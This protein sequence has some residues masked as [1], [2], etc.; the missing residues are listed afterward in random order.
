MA[1][2]YSEILSNAG[3]GASNAVESHLRGPVGIFIQGTPDGATVDVEAN[4]DGSNFHSVQTGLTT[5]YTFDNIVAPY[6][7]AIVN[8][9]TSPSLTVRIYHGPLS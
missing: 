6:V 2:D 4:F 7:R 9:G 3:S 8:G 1:L 5:G